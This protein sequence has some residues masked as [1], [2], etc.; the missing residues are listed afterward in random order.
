MKIEK[1]KMWFKDSIQNSKLIIQ[2]WK[3]KEARKAGM[4]L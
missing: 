4:L 3:N 2:N 1:C